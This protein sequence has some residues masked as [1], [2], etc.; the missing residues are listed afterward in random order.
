MGVADFSNHY[1]GIGDREKRRIGVFRSPRSIR[2]TL[3]VHHL[4]GF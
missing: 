1:A 3:K 2:R 4:V